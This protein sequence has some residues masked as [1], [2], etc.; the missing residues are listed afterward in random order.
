MGK[1]GVAFQWILE[2]GLDGDP[3]DQHLK[4]HLTIEQSVTA[5]SILGVLLTPVFIL[6]LHLFEPAVFVM[7]SGVCGSVVL[8]HIVSTVQYRAALFKNQ[9]PQWNEMD[10]WKTC[11]EGITLFH[12]D[13]WLFYRWGW[14]SHAIVAKTRF[15]FPRGNQSVLF[16]LERKCSSSRPRVT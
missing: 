12:G 4:T 1:S 3:T 9:H 10:G 5:L 14:F 6:P 8:A 13:S 16:W 11:A 7:A 15:F 2:T